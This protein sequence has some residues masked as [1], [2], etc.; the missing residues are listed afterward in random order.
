[1]GLYDR[2]LS[3]TDLSL[4]LDLYDTDFTMTK[5]YNNLAID[6]PPGIMAEGVWLCHSR[7]QNYEAGLIKASHLIQQVHQYCGSGVAGV[8]P[9]TEH[10]GLLPHPLSERDA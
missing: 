4:L 9:S 2:H 8:I 6:F 3:Y 7:Q 10:G 1:M 5:Q